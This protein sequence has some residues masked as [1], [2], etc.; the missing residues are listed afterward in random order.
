MTG[1][2]AYRLQ[3]VKRQ[4][5]RGV[6]KIGG[7]AAIAYALSDRSRTVAFALGAM[8]ATAVMAN[9]WCSAGSAW[10]LQVSVAAQAI[11]QSLP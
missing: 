2:V 4:S 6:E 10:G 11:K 8:R 9:P 7:I 5:M 1:D 3:M